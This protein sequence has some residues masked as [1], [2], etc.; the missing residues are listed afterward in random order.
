MR[1]RFLIETGSDGGYWEMNPTLCLF[2]P[3]VMRTGKT[4]RPA[5]NASGW[6]MG[7]AMLSDKSPASGV[8][9]ASLPPFNVRWDPGR[10]GPDSCFTAAPMSGPA[11]FSAGARDPVVSA[12]VPTGGFAAKAWR[13][14]AFISY[15]HA[16]TPWANWLLK[17]LEGYRVPARFHGHPS[18]VGEVGPR[19]A[20][21]FRDRDELPTTSD[22]GETIRAALGESA[23]LVV[24]CSPSSAQ[25]RWVQEEIIAFKRVHGER[26]VFAFVV[27]GEPKAEGTADDCF[28]PALRRELG[29]DGTLTGAPAE[30]V[31]ADA[32]PHADGKSTAFVRL[33]AGLLG[34]GFDEL[35]QRELQRRNRRLTLITA[36]SVVGMTL[37]LGLAVAAWRARN[38]AQRRQ[39]QA[40]DVLA[41]MLGDFREDLKKV[42]QLALLDKVGN[43]AMRYFDALEASDLTDAAL[44]RQAKALTQI[45]EIRM[46]QIDARYAE[47]AR[48]F[49]PAYQCAAELAARH[50][51]N[52]DMLFER[53]Q[54]EYY[55][56]LVYWRRG[57]LQ[58]A[59][60]WMARYR[61]SAEVLVS[62]SPGSSAWRGELA[63]GHHNLAVVEMEGGR[64]EVAHTAL[65]AEITLLTE[66]GADAPSN[67]DLKFRLADATSW[68]GTLAER[69]GDY[70]EADGRFGAAVVQCERLLEED[71]RSVRSKVALVHALSNRASFLDIS[72]RRAESA[73]L[74][75][76]AAAIIDPLVAADPSNRTWLNAALNLKLKE[77]MSTR[78]EGQRTEAAKLAVEARQGYE[79]LHQVEPTARNY[80]GQLALAWR[81]S[82]ELGLRDNLAEAAQAVAHAMEIGGA[83]I[84]DERT[85]EGF[86][87]D[88]VKACLVRG[89]IA[90]E[91]GDPEGAVKFWRVGVET[92]ANRPQRSNY[93]RLLDP[94]ARVLLRVGRETEGNALIERL[95]KLGYAP[96]TP[97]TEPRL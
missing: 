14:R 7:A 92:M 3:T 20:P 47:A 96:V 56:G 36:A 10:A 68:L 25:S 71:P 18:P 45:G 50:P 57:Q 2:S 35:R 95:R 13:Y 12:V 19:L 54:A 52:G 46:E 26:Q 89:D 38:D 76:R 66:L 22:L 27:A 60:E 34:V 86:M 93:W 84:E 70:A 17:K 48:A 72:A 62:L 97:W 63:W 78:W 28:S 44:A 9:G 94:A 41:F 43:K 16:D 69:V 23:T 53:A 55:I 81:V 42:G 75:R 67:R 51:K 83:L 6:W 88:F 77:A 5:N 32:R 1:K 82:A 33:V 59:K 31:A 79:K 4:G 74:R 85:N 40:E 39:D 21:V 8:G 29:P 15:S 24:I 58:A 37:T 64:H 80:R 87:G 91:N 61:D 90:E 30:V 73:D 11:E 49:H 65:L